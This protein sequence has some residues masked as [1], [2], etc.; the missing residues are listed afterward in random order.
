MPESYILAGDNVASLRT[1]PDNSIDAVVTD[2]PYGLSKEPDIAEVL[3]H[4]L[5]GDD[6]V[7]TGSGFMGKSS[8]CS[9]PAGTS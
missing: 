8:A 1:F 5:A 7:H 6:Y 3:G 2:P 4:W 9:S